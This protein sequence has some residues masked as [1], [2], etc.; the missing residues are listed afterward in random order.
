MGP[1][2]NMFVNALDA[3]SPLTR[4][5]INVAIAVLV[6]LVV[7]FVPHLTD[8]FGLCGSLG[9][10]VFCYLLPGL[11]CLRFHPNVGA[12][13]ICFIASV[14]GLS[15]LVLSTFFILEPYFSH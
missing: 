7:L 8:V 12:K 11:V 4:P 15:M 5:I 9:V 10:S 13:V 2:V 6:V 14:V 3:A 1:V